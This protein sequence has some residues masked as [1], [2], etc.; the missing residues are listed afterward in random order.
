LIVA[1]FWAGKRM[2][3]GAYSKGR[4][5]SQKHGENSMPRGRLIEVFVAKKRDE[6]AIKALAKHLNQGTAG[7][8]AARTKRKKGIKK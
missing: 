1:E 5:D 3:P 4:W 2:V 6:K 7:Q 8:R